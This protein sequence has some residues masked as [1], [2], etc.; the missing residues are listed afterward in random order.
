LKRINKIREPLEGELD[1]IKS[2]L[3]KLDKFNESFEMKVD[4]N[5]NRKWGD[6][7]DTIESR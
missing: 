1:K 7:E 3:D 2:E 6:P 4:P 5:I